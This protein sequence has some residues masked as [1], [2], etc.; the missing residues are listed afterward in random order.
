MRRVKVLSVI[1]IPAMKRVKILSVIFVFLLAA[2]SLPA[3]VVTVAASSN[4]TYT[5]PVIPSDNADPSYIRGDDGY[6]YL[7]ATGERMWRSS[8][9]ISWSQIGTA[10]GAGQ[11][12]EYKGPNYFWAPSLN[13]IGDRY[14]MYFAVGKMGGTGD[15]FY[16]GVATSDTPGGPYAIYD[17]PATPEDERGVLFLSSTIGVAQ[18]IDPCYIEAD[19]HK[20]LFW[21]SYHEIDAIELDSTGLAV[22][23]GAQKVK[24]GGSAYE[25]TYIMKHGDYYYF[26]GSNGTCCNGAESTYKVVYGRSKNVLGPYVNKAGGRLLDNQFD[27]LIQGNDK[28]AGTG[29]NA[30]ITEDADGEWWIMYHAYSKTNPSLGRLVLLDRVQWIDGWPYVEGGTPS[31]RSKRPAIR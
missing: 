27:I 14:V 28:W 11:H 3:Q 20:Y 8:N 13:K 21:G 16:I 29:H 17:N 9:M 24:V 15:D 5:N 30:E 23:P 18:S 31:E 22:K 10:F 2:T 4:D 7:C 19:G 26:F 12:P 1:F 25:G 6:L